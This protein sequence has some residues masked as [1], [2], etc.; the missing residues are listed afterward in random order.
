GRIWLRI[1]CIN[2]R[3]AT[4]HIEIDDMFRLAAT[5]LRDGGICSDRAWTE[6]L[7]SGA[8][9]RETE[10][11]PCRAGEK[12]ATGKFVKFVRIHVNILD[13]DEMIGSQHGPCENAQ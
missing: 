3:H 2:V 11:S 5:G 1:K 6:K 4:S 13:K 12:I 7:R 9:N 8:C 10:A